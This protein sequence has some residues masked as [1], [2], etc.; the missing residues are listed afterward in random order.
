[1]K[2]IH[3]HE[4][5]M[6]A[7]GEEPGWTSQVREMT[8]DV[9]ASAYDLR[10][11]ARWSACLDSGSYAASQAMDRRVRT[12]QGG[13]LTAMQLWTTYLKRV[14]R[15]EAVRI[16][17]DSEMLKLASKYVWW[18][19]PEHVLENQ[20]DRLVANVMELG[21]WE[22][23][24]RLLAEVGRDRFISVLDAPPPGI[25]SAKSL[26]FWH[27]RLG[28]PGDPPKPTVRSFR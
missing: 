3:H 4:R 1:M 18:S 20:V 11:D 5:A 24:N 12:E 19:P 28:R 9:Q 25:V 21:T 10:G 22:D 7:S 27:R 2:T 26:A 16:S 17:V 8:L 13:T 14:T 23:A 6:A 15:G